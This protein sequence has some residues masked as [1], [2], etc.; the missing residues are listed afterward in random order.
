[1]AKPELVLAGLLVGLT[2]LALTPW[3][4]AFP[5]P[6]VL[7]VLGAWVAAFVLWAGYAA[8]LVARHEGRRKSRETG[9]PPKPN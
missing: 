9:G 3:A 2:V 5:V 8:V 7:R 4:A 6:V 1:M